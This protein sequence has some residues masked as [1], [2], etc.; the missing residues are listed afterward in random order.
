MV[1]HHGV[2]KLQ[3][4]PFLCLQLSLLPISA[5]RK[6]MRRLSRTRAVLWSERN[7]KRGI[8]NHLLSYR[9]SFSFI[10][11]NDFLAGLVNSS[12]PKASG[13]AWWGLEEDKKICQHPADSA[14]KKPEWKIK[15]YYNNYLSKTAYVGLIE[16]KYYH[17]RVRLKHLTNDVYSFT[18]LASN[19]WPYL[20]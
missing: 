10:E 5:C 19:T 1:Q 13:I 7:C 4:F 9:P 16:S 20:Y 17:D 8:E 14:K 18:L 12:T 2:A 6:T 15:C 3:R 11:K